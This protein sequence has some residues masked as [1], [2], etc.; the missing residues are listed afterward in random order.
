[1]LILHIGNKNY[2]S[3]SM[4][5]WVAMTAFG[6]P[7]EERLHWLDTPGFAAGLAP[8]SPVARVPI[9]EDGA[10]RIWDSLAIVEHLAEQS[11]QHALWPRETAARARARSLCAS[12]HSGFM[13][14]RERMNMNIEAEL[15]GRGWNPE[16]QRDIEVILRM[17]HD[18]LQTSGG[19]FLFGAFGLAD[20]FYAPVCMRFLTYRPELPDWAWAYVQA[21]AAHPAVDAWVQQGK[22]ERVFLPEHEPYRQS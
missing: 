19:P 14:L 16:V 7:F 11:P 22:A 9:L 12:M 13:A 5:P 21:V 3:W 8:L 4:R 18:A 15:P 10:L 1:M 17:W 6:I 20:A 2:S